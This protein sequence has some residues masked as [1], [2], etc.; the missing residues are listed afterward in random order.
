M[1]ITAK[2]YSVSFFLSFVFFNY[3][4]IF[5]SILHQRTLVKVNTNSM[6]MLGSITT[7]TMMMMIMM[8]TNKDLFK[9]NHNNDNNI[10]MIIIIIMILIV[11]IVKCTYQCC[12]GGLTQGTPG[13][14]HNDVC[15]PQSVIL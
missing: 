7:I 10:I 13:H 5:E 9:E 11:I 1:G 8:M 15:K 3:S 14:L 12:S 6:S 2:I 4:N